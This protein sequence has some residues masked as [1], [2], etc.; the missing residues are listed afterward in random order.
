MTILCILLAITYFL[1]YIKSDYL[2]MVPTID[3]LLDY[4]IYSAVTC[5]FTKTPHPLWTFDD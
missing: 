3:A 1:P 4:C 5:L 2:Y